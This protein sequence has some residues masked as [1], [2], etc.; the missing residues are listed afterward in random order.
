MPKRTRLNNRPNTPSGG[1]HAQVKLK[2]WAY[3][4][5]EEALNIIDAFVKRGG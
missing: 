2:H 3:Y 4:L 5:S 1:C